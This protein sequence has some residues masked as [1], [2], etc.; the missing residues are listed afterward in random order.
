MVTA[1][2]GGERC[3]VELVLVYL[4]SELSCGLVAWLV[5]WLTLC[6]CLQSPTCSCRFSTCARPMRMTMQTIRYVHTHTHTHTHTL[7]LSL[8]HTVYIFR[9]LSDV[10]VCVGRRGYGAAGCAARR[11]RSKIFATAKMLAVFKTLRYNSTL[12]DCASAT[13][14]PTF[15]SFA[16]ACVV[17]AFSK[18]C[19]C[20][21]MAAWCLGLIVWC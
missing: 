5:G 4:R 18:L 20:C 14:N 1:V 13:P 3:A 11:I 9:S 8:S 21:S 16:C 6:F 15:S 2:R 10:S 17:F 19:C 12:F 7:S